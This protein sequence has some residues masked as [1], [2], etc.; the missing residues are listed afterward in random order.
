MVSKLLQIKKTNACFFHMI[1]LADIARELGISLSVV[2]RALSSNPDRHAVIRDETR[3]RIRECAVRMGYQPNRQA[4]FLGKR[5][6][7]ATIFCFLPDVPTRL[8]SD[9][10]FGITETATSEN[11]PVNFVFGKKSQDLSNFIDYS[12]ANAHAGLLT[13]PTSKMSAD[14]LKKFRE[15]YHSDGKI[16]FLNTISNL[17]SQK[18]FQEFQEFQGIPTLNIDERFGGQLAASHLIKCKCK[19]IYILTAN[20]PAIFG[21]REKGFLEV[22]AKHNIQ[23]NQVTFN[24]LKKMTLP[25]RERIGIFADSDYL[26]LD[27]YSVLSAKGMTVG[28]DIMLCG[29]DDIFYGRI[30][31]PSLTTVH[32]PMRIEGQ[33][34]IN[35]LISM[36]FG[37][38]EK[39]E[40]LKPFLFQRE[41]TGGKRPDPELPEK[42]IK[43]TDI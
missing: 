6:K 9:L 31:A 35:K 12:K 26:A 21:T 42:E 22:S 23:V 13:Y 14:M 34:A 20:Q 8:M 7:S 39:D 29:F 17:Y 4:S 36:I 16:L 28:K 33:R 43:I 40:L 25:K 3:A 19:N 38:Q 41:S 2:S 27:A 1:R 11:F 10:L 30:A 32:Q 37:N 5:G 15:Y 24:E 18:A